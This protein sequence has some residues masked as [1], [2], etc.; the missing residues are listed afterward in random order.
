VW[1]SHPSSLFFL[2]FFV[3]FFRPRFFQ[4]DLLSVGPVPST[5]ED[6]CA[7]ERE[8]LLLLSDLPSDAFLPS[9]NSENFS[10]RERKRS[11][12]GHPHPS[13]TIVLSAG[14]VRSLNSPF[15]V[16]KFQLDA[17]LSNSRVFPLPSFFFFPPPAVIADRAALLGDVWLLRLQ[18]PPNSSLTSRFVPC[19]DSLSPCLAQISGVRPSPIVPTSLRRA[20]LKQKITWST[21]SIFVLIGLTSSFSRTFY[22]RPPAA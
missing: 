12:S 19:Q 5:P 1:C 3:H 18:M 15:Q 11:P 17:F 20:R 14:V 10:L 21:P 22:L 6:R 4:W 7:F 8:A 9:P 2:S 16:R 13:D